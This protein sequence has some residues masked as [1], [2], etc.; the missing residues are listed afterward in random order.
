MEQIL[1]EAL[2]RDMEDRAVI[3]NS[4]HGFSK[5]KSYLSSLVAF[6]DGVTVS[7]D[8]GKAMDVTYLYVCKAFDTVPCNILLPK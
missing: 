5:D 6:Y 2:L 8:K 1:P 7:V 4:Q 3:G